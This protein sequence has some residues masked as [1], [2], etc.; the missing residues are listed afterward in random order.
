MTRRLV[1]GVGSAVVAGVLVGIV[2]RLLMRVTTLAAG[3]SA[4]FSWS[5][6]AGIVVLYVAAMI[7]GALLVA[8]TGGRRSWLL[9]S[10]A[11]F[12]CLPAIGVA[13]EEIGY[14]GDLSVVRLLAVGLS[15]AAVFA[16]L[17][18]LPVLTLRLVRRS[19]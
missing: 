7:P 17:A 14:L 11:A 5:G 4:G 19:T 10:G 2:S 16:T 3:G 13:S 9:A 8:T 12:L 6:S 1:A 18:L 15:G